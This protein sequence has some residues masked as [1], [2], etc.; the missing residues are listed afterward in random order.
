MLCN[1]FEP[2]CQSFPPI[3]KR[4]TNGA[5][6]QWQITV[7]GSTFFVTE[8]LVGGK[9][10]TSIPTICKGKNIGKRNETT[11]I[12]QALKQAKALIKKKLES[13]Y[14][15]SIDDIDIP[16]FFRVMLANDYNDYK[17]KINYPIFYQPKL[18]GIRCVVSKYGMFSR[19]GKQFKSVPHILEQLKELFYI[20]E[21]FIF[22]GELYCDKLKND[23]NTISSLV[24]K[25]KPSQDDL[26]ESR[27]V[28]Q[29]WIYDFPYQDKIF[30]KR[31]GEMVNLLSS[32]KNRDSLVIV[33]T[34]EAH[35][36]EQLTK[37]YELLV[38]DGYEGQIVRI[39]V[40]YENKRTNMLLKR[41]EFM[42]HEF[43]IIDVV[44]G[45][46]NRTGTAGYFILRLEN[47]NNFRSNIKG[48]FS[49]LKE[50]LLN[51]NKLIGKQATVKF[52]N[53]T[54]DGVPR[55]PYVIRI[56]DYE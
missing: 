50:L 29:Y 21:N 6:Q 17:H 4:T 20:D 44:E 12:E 15:E 34:W 27:K 39:D 5:I 35:N 3:Y 40:P 1:N 2:T 52:F 22:D 53:W 48:P 13:G 56:R 45:I 42:D 38:E 36:E 33:P 25:Q 32:I 16:D 28:I 49:Y 54:P 9:Q 18:D 26:N 43:E 8:G 41:K 46:G 30:S 11:P 31:F 55:F 10:T 19:N 51:K 37:A 24:K 47:G 14:R 7:K 23:F